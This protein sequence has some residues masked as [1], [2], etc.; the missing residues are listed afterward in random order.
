MLIPPIIN[1][2]FKR[3]VLILWKQLLTQR[4]FAGLARTNQRYTA[5]LFYQPGNEFFEV[6]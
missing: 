5:I 1:R 3:E 6:P 2:Q 4:G